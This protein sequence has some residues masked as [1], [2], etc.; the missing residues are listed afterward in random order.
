MLFLGWAI[1]RSFTH[2]SVGKAFTFGV[3]EDTGWNLTSNVS[4][5]ET[6]ALV[7]DKTYLPGSLGIENEAGRSA[8]G[9]IRNRRSNYLAVHRGGGG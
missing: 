9:P 5:L 3:V 8:N 4:Y 1:D 7:F 2:S 6:L